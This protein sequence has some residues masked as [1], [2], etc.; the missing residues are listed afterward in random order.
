MTMTMSP[1]LLFTI[2]FRGPFH[3]GG[4]APAAG[5]DRP[6]D[7]EN[8]LPGTSLKGL[9]R[10]EARERLRIREDLVTA[11]FGGPG[12]DPSPWWFSDAH[13]RATAYGRAARIAIEDSAGTTARGMLLLGEQVWA[14]SATF[15]VAPI[16][17]PPPSH[18]LVL[19]AAGRSVS[20]LGGER[21]RGQGWVT[22]TDAEPWT[23]EDSA[24]L[25]KEMSQ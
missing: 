7:R 11:V 25:V 23:A 13:F 17:D 5:L 15:E 2:T 22:I 21:R 18:R 19:R 8:P 12:A 24:A 6:L 14:D 1:K 9:L 16:A 20:S 3:V 10:A 4:T